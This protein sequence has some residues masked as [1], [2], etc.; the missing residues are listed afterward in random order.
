[1][2]NNISNFSDIRT[3]EKAAKNSRLQIVD[4]VS[5]YNHE[6]DWVA[7]CYNPKFRLETEGTDVP[8]SY[9]LNFLFFHNFY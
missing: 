6:C 8:V 3:Y 1:M 9:N 4:F 2:F 5:V 7:S